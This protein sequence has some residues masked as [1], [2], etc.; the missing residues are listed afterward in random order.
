MKNT[1]HDKKKKKV[2]ASNLNS[3]GKGRIPLGHTG[4]S[5][6]AAI[7]TTEAGTP[8]H[9]CD[10]SICSLFLHTFFSIIKKKKKEFVFMRKGTGLSL[11]CFG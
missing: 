7:H 10:W 1:K 2:T 6:L 3:K 5:N 9:L 11:I 4:Q 8:L